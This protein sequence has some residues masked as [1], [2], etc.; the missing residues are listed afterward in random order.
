MGIDLADKKPHKHRGP[1]YRSPNP[2]IRLLV[3]LYRYLAERT[4][5]RF[6]ALVLKRLSYSKSNR[7][8]VSLSKICRYLKQKQKHEGTQAIEGK[9]LSEAWKAGKADREKAEKDKADKKAK[10]KAD[11]KV[12][13]DKHKTDRNA[14][15]KLRADRKA[16]KAKKQAA[17]SKDKKPE[18][19]KE[20]AKKDA[21]KKDKKQ[22]KKKVPKQRLAL[23]NPVLAAKIQKKALKKQAAGEK[24]GEAKKEVESKEKKRYEPIVVVVGTVTDDERFWQVEKFTLCALHVTRTAEFRILKAG[25]R[26]ITFDQLALER[27]LGQGTVIL[28]GRRSNREQLRHFRGHRGTKHVVP[29]IKKGSE[30]YGRRNERSKFRKGR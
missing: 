21:P 22:V 5:S 30:K 7:P 13:L 29:R 28:Q 17:E 16:E 26:I 20:P 3:R 9:K 14:R 12:I 11:A 6:H 24:K 19:A 25:G 23:L 4:T 2:Y 27:P 18:P 10:E 15:L 1:R 8:P